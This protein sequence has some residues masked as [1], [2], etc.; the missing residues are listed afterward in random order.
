M[1]SERVDAEG[2]SNIAEAAKQFLPERKLAPEVENV[3]KMSS[4]SDLDAW[5]KLDDVIMGGKS[6]SK[7]QTAERVEIFE[8][9]NNAPKGT[10]D[11]DG[12]V[13]RGELVVE[14]GGF[15]GT[16]TKVSCCVHHHSEHALQ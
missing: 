6:G 5:E 16:R 7:M 12:A 1:T 9:A 2:I 15:C 14:G 8:G 4:D 3:L 10:Y 13:W 11:Y